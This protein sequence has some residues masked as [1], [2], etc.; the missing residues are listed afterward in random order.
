MHA[1]CIP[2]GVHPH[3]VIAWHSS[4]FYIKHNGP[5]FVSSTSEDE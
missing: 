1:E 4:G 2:I 3:S 5:H